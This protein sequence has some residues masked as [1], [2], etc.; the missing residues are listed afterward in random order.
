MAKKKSA[1]ESSGSALSRAIRQ[2]V[3]SG[4]VEF[5]SNS[6]IKRALSGK[7]KMV[8]LAKNCPS[9]LSQD[10]AR[11]CKLSGV[12]LVAFDGTSLD[13]G[14]VAGK[15]Y[16]VAMLTVLDPGNSGILELSK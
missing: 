16:P 8:V 5:G 3:D 12:P 11:F 13:L 6:G 9:S 15:P 1:V 2:C 14:T 7:A 4:K 10:A